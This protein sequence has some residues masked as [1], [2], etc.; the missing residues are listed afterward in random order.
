[1]QIIH[2]WRDTRGFECSNPKQAPKGS[3]TTVQSPKDARFSLLQFKR[4]CAKFNTG[5]ILLVGE[6]L[7][8]V[9]RSDEI[10]LE[11]PTRPISL[12]AFRRSFEPE[13]VP[14]ATR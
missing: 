4:F 9:V 6:C 7:K 5:R 1:M 13:P 2:L 11:T 12:E 8:Q 14:A 10:S 3:L